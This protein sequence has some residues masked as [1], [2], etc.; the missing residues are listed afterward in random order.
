M[1]WT[2]QKFSSKTLR[3]IDLFVFDFHFNFS[4]FNTSRFASREL[5]QTVNIFG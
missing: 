2:H 5:T 4:I 1:I 3:E